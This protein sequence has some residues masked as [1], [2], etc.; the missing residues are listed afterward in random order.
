MILRLPSPGEIKEVFFEAMLAG[1]ASNAPKKLTITE[2]PGSKLILFEKGPW[3]VAD[4]YYTRRGSNFSAGQ[5][6]ISHDGRP[7]WV[8]SYQGCY[9]RKVIPFLKKALLLSY[10]AR[11]WNGGRGP[12][13]FRDGDLQYTNQVSRGYDDFTDFRG[14]EEVRRMGRPG[15]DSVGLHDYMGMVI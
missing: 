13:T 11:L 14:S 1:Y 15:G 12:D 2:L 5:T 6:I 10:E 8:M 3:R 7:V 9:E 4:V